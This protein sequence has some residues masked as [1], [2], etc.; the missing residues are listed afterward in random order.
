MEELKVGDKLFGD[1]LYHGLTLVTV[2][3]LTPT[4][5]VLSNDS[6]LRKPFRGYDTAIGEGGYGSSCYIPANDEN[7]QKYKNQQCLRKIKNIDFTKLQTTVL[8][9][10]I[11]LAKCNQSDQ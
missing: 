8:E 10:I 9:Q 7:T 4:Q 1:S 5:Y 6:R 11:T 3:R 2:K